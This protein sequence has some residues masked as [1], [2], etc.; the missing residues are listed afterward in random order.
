MKVFISHYSGEK[1]LAESLSNWLEVKLRGVRIFCSSRPG[2]IAGEIWRDKVIQEA[3]END[4]EIALLSPE[5]LGN[6]WIQFETGLASATEKPRI[7]P[8]VYGGLKIKDVPSTLS[9]WEILDLTDGREFDATLAK[10]FENYYDKDSPPTLISFLDS[11]DSSVERMIRYGPLAAW[12]KGKILTKPQN[13]FTLVPG[14]DKQYFKISEEKTRL[15]AIRMRIRPRSVGG[16][17]QWKCGV[18]LKKSSDPT[19]ENREFAFH[20]GNHYGVMSFSLY[21]DNRGGAPIN[22][23]ADLTQ[24][25][26]H[27]IQ[28]WFGPGFNQVQVAGIDVSGKY[29]KITTDGEDRIWRPIIDECNFALV[30]AWAD[31]RPFR[32]TIEE[33]EIDYFEKCD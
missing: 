31:Q 6:P 25:K 7:V 2:E 1:E 17:S 20:T 32:V 3:K 8:A 11:C 10:I 30:Y 15:S 12:L 18:S 19:D 14:E 16:V 4:L 23:P 24:E 27:S 26:D 33:L 29:Y 13:S 22:I 5:S 21:P 28:L 9:N